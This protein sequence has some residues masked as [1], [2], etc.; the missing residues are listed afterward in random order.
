MNGIDLMFA[1]SLHGLTY[2]PCDKENHIGLLSSY[3]KIVERFKYI[4]TEFPN[5][6]ITNI[7]DD[8]GYGCFEIKLL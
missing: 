8:F 2:R 1:S 3:E 6:V 4:K 7:Y 5:A